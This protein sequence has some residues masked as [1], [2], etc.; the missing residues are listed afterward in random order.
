MLI[1]PEHLPLGFLVNTVGRLLHAEST[2]RFAR[3]DIDPV[4]VGVLWTINL[5]P[6][7]SQADY[8]AYQARDATTYGRMVDKLANRGLIERRPL[9]N[10]RR[11]W[12]LALTA[13]GT[14]LLADLAIEAKA[15][16]ERFTRDIPPEDARAMRRALAQLL[17]ALGGL[18]VEDGTP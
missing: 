6:G 5:M 10:D 14:A 16:E 7:R 13:K 9:P 2:A 3:E 18:A 4:L 15:V 12:S 1:D 11:A 8:A 17:R